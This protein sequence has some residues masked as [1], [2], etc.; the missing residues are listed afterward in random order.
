MAVF[1]DF[2]E[3]HVAPFP[4]M[5]RISE[6]GP[7]ET[8]EQVRRRDHRELHVVSTSIVVVYFSCAWN[9]PGSSPGNC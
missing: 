3:G 6:P 8:A 7:P 5:N 1:I 4:L 2:E 9:G